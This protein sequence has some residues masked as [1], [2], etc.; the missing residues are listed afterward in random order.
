[1]PIVVVILGI[2]LIVGAGAYFL[3]PEEVVPPTADSEV[4]IPTPLP[5][6]DETAPVEATP[7]VETT[8]TIKSA[9]TEETTVTEVAADT[10]KDGTYTVSA[11]Y[12]APSRSS[13]D[14]EVTLTLLD[15][16]VTDATVSFGGDTDVD[17]SNFNQN[18]FV[19]AY[20]TLVIGKELDNISLSR[21]GG[22]SLTTNAFND[23]LAKIKTEAQS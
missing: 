11:N 7:A 4:V 12:I 1:M 6:A 22:A 17:A 18:K 13:H 15:D 21:V 10:Y 20:K 23:A 9:G 5:N 19:A 2:A 3:R 16:V 14:V 8:S